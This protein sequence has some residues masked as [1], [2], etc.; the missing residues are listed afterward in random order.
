MTFEWTTPSPSAAL[1]KPVAPF[2]R[3]GPHIAPAFR[4]S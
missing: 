4:D 2:H 3:S 1:D